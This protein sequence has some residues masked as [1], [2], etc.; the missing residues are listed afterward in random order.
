MPTRKTKKTGRVTRKKGRPK[1]LE[2]KAKDPNAPQKRRGR[3]K[4]VTEFVEADIAGLR[5]ETIPFS[6]IDL[7][8]HQFRFRVNLRIGNLAGSIAAEGQQF[9]VILRRKRDGKLQVISGFRRLAAIDKL[10]WDKVKAVIRN[11]LDDDAEACRVS[12]LENEIRQTYND[13]DRAYAILAYRRMGKTAG[14]IEEIFKVGARQ[15]QRLEELTT[16]PKALQNAVADGRVPSTH[17]VKLMQHA[18]KFEDTDI[19]AWIKWIADDNASMKQLNAALKEEV[20]DGKRGQP[21]ELF[22]AKEKDG[23]RSL[24]IRPI[25]ID[26]SLSAKQRKALL[27]DLKRVIG[28][29]ERL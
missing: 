5:I 16:F 14:E 28:F 19:S 27:K 11:D 8:D 22:V 3:P 1:N 29:V 24:R 9:P 7:S 6:E 2:K 4:K 21:V 10:G 18:R 12:I 17:A 26:E 23:R 13:L 25:S 20:A 15:R